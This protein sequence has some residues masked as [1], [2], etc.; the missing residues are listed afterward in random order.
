MTFWNMFWI[1]VG[2]VIVFTILLILLIASGSRYS[3]A[4]TEAD[5]VDFPA[6]MKEGH[7]GM[8]AFLWITFTGMFIWT[9]IYFIQHWHEFAIITAYAR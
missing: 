9:I 4:D 2:S 8:T 3:V 6:G 7:G 1:A 5:A